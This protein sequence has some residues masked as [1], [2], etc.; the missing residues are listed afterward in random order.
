MKVSFI[1]TVYNEEKTIKKYLDSLY[2]Q[3]QLPGEI[4]IVDGGSSDATVNVLSSFKQ[5]I[6]KKQKKPV[7]NF[8]VKKGNRSVGRN[9][10]IKQATGDIIACS[11]SGNILDQNWIKNITS[12]FSDLKVDVVAGYY[13]GL[14]K[15]VFQKCVIPY[16][17][18]MPDKVDPNN[19]L[20]ATRSVA[21]KKSLWKKIGGFNEAFSHNEDYVFARSLKDAGATIYFAK[22]ALVYWLPRNDLRTT[23]IMMWRFA[24]GDAEARIFRP[25]VAFLFARYL[26][27]AA[28]LL[29]SL[30]TK[31]IPGLL[32]LMGLLFFYISW[33]ILKNYRYVKDLRAIYFLP[34]IQFTADAAVLSGTLQG[35]MKSPGRN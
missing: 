16:A 4:I 10:A 20:P 27:G 2:K 34:V 13:K 14:A 23:F 28:L 12:P 32:L 1:T 33:A 29:F 21:F 6:S 19:F 7:I 17:L 31:S 26:I 30:I 5:Q 15:T 9:E 22:N 35:L 18:V 3:T 25:K 24:R 11:D 8:S